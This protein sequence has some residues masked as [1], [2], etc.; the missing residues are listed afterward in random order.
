M[1]SMRT[2]EMKLSDYGIDDSRKKELL[3]MAMRKENR[4]ALEA[5]AKISN[6][7]L[8]PYLVASLVSEK[9]KD[10]KSKVGSRTLFRS[11]Y[12]PPCTEDDFYAYRRK[13]LAVFN[14]FI[15]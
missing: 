8:A 9:N 13:T 11:M 15:K 1:Y 4:E 7:A 6:P 14:Y 12:Y 2:R 3:E 10:G 5:A